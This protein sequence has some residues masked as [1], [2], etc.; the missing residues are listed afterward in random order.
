MTKLE[1][2]KKIIKDY[3]DDARYGIFNCS[4]LA[5]DRMTTLY[6]DDELIIKICY[7]WG[8]FEVFGL[9]YEEFEK[10]EDYYETCKN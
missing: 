5:G 10:L 4:N 2:A 8:Y 9:T 6:E 1:K 7:N 3:I